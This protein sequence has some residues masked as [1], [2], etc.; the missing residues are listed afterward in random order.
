[1]QK[2]REV[3]D[4]KAH[5]RIL[6]SL[7]N[8]Q[9]G[10]DREEADK[11]L[12]S[13]QGKMTILEAIA[14]RN[15]FKA[16]TPDGDTIVKIMWEQAD[17]RPTVRLTGPDDGPIQIERTVNIKRFSTEQLRLWR[18]LMSIAMAGNSDGEG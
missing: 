12:K 17:G 9:F 14:L 6:R 15:T 4:Q 7:A 3:W 8:V 10:E 5:D 2:H 18:E 11:W 13:V 1:M 16:M